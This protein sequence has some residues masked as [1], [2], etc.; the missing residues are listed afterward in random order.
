MKKFIAI[1]ATALT[2]TLAT[3]QSANAA[4]YLC[5]KNTPFG[6]SSVSVGGFG[7]WFLQRNGYDCFVQNSHV[8]VITAPKMTVR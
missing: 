8:M 2:L 3:S 5:L 6:E 7:K 4:A 1:A